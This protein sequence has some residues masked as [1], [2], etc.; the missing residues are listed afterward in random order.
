MQIVGISSAILPL[1]VVLA[2]CT[3]ER[4]R[5][6]E[7]VTTTSAE[8]TALERE[9]PARPIDTPANEVA[10]PDVDSN[11]VT[12]VRDALGAADAGRKVLRSD[13]R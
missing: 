1:A 4:A 10:T 7:P 6:I 13:D 11:S 12:G 8:M 9:Y 2:G 5:Q 3:N